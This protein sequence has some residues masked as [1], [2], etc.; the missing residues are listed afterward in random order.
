[1]QVPGYNT[2]CP[3][4]Q[5]ALRPGV[6]PELRDR[7]ARG[8][9]SRSSS[10]TLRKRPSGTPERCVLYPEIIVFVRF[11]ARFPL[12]GGQEWGKSAF[13]LQKYLENI[14]QFGKS[15]YL[16]TRFRAE[17]GAWQMKIDL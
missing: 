9:R 4:V 15:L 2:S 10:W 16:C 8:G 17:R 5:Y 12:D 11:S 3:A 6:Q 13:F 7:A 1:M 14:C